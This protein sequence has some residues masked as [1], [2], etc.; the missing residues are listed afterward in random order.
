[1]CKSI[2]VCVVWGCLLF[3]FLIPLCSKSILGKENPLFP[4]RSPQDAAS[5]CRLN[6]SVLGLS[7]PDALTIL[8]Q[9]GGKQRRRKLF[10]FEFVFFLISF[11]PPTSFL[12]LPPQ[13]C[14]GL[15]PRRQS[16][17]PAVHAS[18]GAG[19]GCRGR[20]QMVGVYVYKC[21][22]SYVHEC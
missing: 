18:L 20:N 16:T 19:I 13:H 5:S 8:E 10:C 12:P 1:M 2:S 6:T 14:T 21:M 7:C 22:A 3:F 4:R 9:A 11:F 17:F 15:A